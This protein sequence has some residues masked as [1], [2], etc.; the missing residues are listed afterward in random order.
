MIPEV[1]QQLG[2]YEILG[3]L[4]GGGMAKVFRGWDRRLRR[5]VA[6]KLIRRDAELV[7]VRERFL[8]EARAA[9]GLV[10]PNICTIF[11]LWEQDGELF[12]VMELLQGVTLKERIAG[13]ALPWQEVVRYGREMAGALALAHGRG[14][15][16]R[17]IKPANIF[18]AI[19]PNG[20][21]QAKL[22]DFGLAKQGHEEHS[23]SRLTEMGQTLG[24]VAYMS[25]EQ[26]RGEPLDGRS[27]LFSLGVVLYEM[28]TGR[29]LFQGGTSA[30]VFAQLL[31]KGW[32]EQARSLVRG[33]PKGLERIIRRL[34]EREPGRRF[35]SAEELERAL[36]AL[37][38]RKESKERKESWFGWSRSAEVV[39]RDPATRPKY[40]SRKVEAPRILAVWEDDE[41]EGEAFLI[42]PRVEAPRTGEVALGQGA[43]PARGQAATQ[44]PVPKPQFEPSSTLIEPLSKAAPGLA[45]RA[46]SGEVS[47][48]AESQPMQEGGLERARRRMA[49]EVRAGVSAYRPV[50]TVKEWP[51]LGSGFFDEFD[52][53]EDGGNEEAVTAGRGRRRWWVWVVVALL[54][55]ALVGVILARR[56]L[57]ASDDVAGSR[58]AYGRFQELWPGADTE[59][60]L[61]VE[62]R[63]RAR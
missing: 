35:P 12:L 26:A 8:R 21:S 33:T 61:V 57:A 40:P 9:S 18:L 5:E 24:T 59:S 54:I 44:Q 10:H 41:E 28:A 3:E 46:A 42:P 31:G 6:I 63:D 50:I 25:P 16:H 47:A 34:L 14:I 17:D 38:E 49:G 1:G 32:P 39:A 4:A 37:G 56:A 7:E 43:E 15:V 11:D 60:P 58:M 30:V 23:G 51:E 45:L 22:L 55:A 36:A 62:V 2:P 52:E 48:V 29:E 27:D 19:Q 53:E 20:G 13:G